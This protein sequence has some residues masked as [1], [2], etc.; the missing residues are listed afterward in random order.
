MPLVETYQ[1][2]V[3]LPCHHDDLYPV[4]IDLATEPLKMRV[5][6]Q[7]P[8][9]SPDPLRAT[10]RGGDPR[11]AAPLEQPLIAEYQ[12]ADGTAAGL[13]CRT[14]RSGLRIGAAMDHM[15]DGPKGTESVS[16]S[17]EDQARVAVTARR[18]ESI[19]CRSCRSCRPLR[20][21]SR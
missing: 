10:S 9:A 11:M 6:E 18:L 1:P 15:I 5:H 19:R 17:F 14:K 20:S 13:V 7:L 21:R 12:G 3:V 16:E 4:F 8:E 2:K